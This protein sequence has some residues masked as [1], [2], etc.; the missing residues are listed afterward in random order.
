M[1]RIS[2]IRN[3]E[4]ALREFEEGEADLASV[5]RTVLAVVR[6]YATAFSEDGLAAY[7]VAPAAADGLPVTVVAGSP[8]AARE[9]AR[10]LADVSPVAV[11]RLPDE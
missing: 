5:E 11:E 10:E 8:G 9:R 2:A 4:D 3:V 1:D 7:R 6:T